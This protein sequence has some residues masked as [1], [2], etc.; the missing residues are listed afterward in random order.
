MVYIQK[1][2]Y[3]TAASSLINVLAHVK[4]DY[5]PS[6]EDEFKIWMESA[7]LPIRASSIFGLALAAKKRSLKPEVY[8]ESEEYDFPDYRFYR[9]KKEDVEL[10][11]KSSEIYKKKAK[12]ENINTVTTQINIDLIKELLRKNYLLVRINVKDLRNLK[13]NSSNYLM[14]KNYENKEFTI[15]D[16]I[17]GEIKV[18]EDTIVSCLESLEKKKHR[19][20]KLISIMKN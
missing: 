4:K 6:E 20:R 5:S 1:T 14:F 10:A 13:S 19:S 15:I 7:N 9:Y 17:Q 8:V 3:T 2:P 11:K 12:K 18:K 16:P